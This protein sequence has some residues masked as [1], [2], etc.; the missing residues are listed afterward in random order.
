MNEVAAAFAKRDHAQ[1]QVFL[2][3]SGSRHGASAAN[4]ALVLAFPLHL[5][6]DS[7]PPEAHCYFRTLGNTGCGLR[8]ER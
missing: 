6:A 3:E 7:M 5:A 8:K 4:V 1:P 2:L